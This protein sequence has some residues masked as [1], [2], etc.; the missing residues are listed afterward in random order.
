MRVD[1]GF[2]INHYAGKVI[3]NASG[4]LAKNRDALP[5][6]IILLLRSSENELIRKLVTNPLTK[7]A[8]QPYIVRGLFKVKTFP[9]QSNLAHTKGK[10][11]GS[12]RL[13][14]RQRSP[15]RSVN[16]VKG[17]NGAES[18]HHPRETTNM[19][20][21][22]V[23]SYFR[24]SLMDLLSKMVAGQ[25][26]FIRCIK[27]NNDR[28]A[29]KF[30]REKVLIQLRYTGI[31]ETAKIRRQGY[32]HRILFANFIQRYY[33][34]AF[35]MNEEP[36]VSRETCAAILEKAKLENWA[37]GKTK[38]FLKYYHVEHLNLMVRRTMDRV[39]L[40]QAYVRCWLVVQ[41]YRK[42]LGKRAQSAVVLQSAFR[43][44][45]VRKQMADDKT[46]AEQDT[47]IVELQ[48]VCRGYLARK[49]YKELVDEKNKA[50]TK[51]QAHFRGHKERRSFQRKKE[52][53]QKEN[54][55]NTEED[56]PVEESK[57]SAD[58]AQEDGVK[59]PGNSEGKITPSA[60]E[61]EAASPES[62]EE[63][64]PNEAT[65]EEV[66]T[67]QEAKAATVIQSNFRGY[68]ERKKLQEDGQLPTKGKKDTD[69]QTQENNSE[70]KTMEAGQVTEDGQNPSQGQNNGSENQNESGS[71][72]K[73][74]AESRTAQEEPEKEN[75]PTEPTSEGQNGDESRQMD[76]EQA[77][78]EKSDL[79]SFSKHISSV[80]QD[81]LMLQQ[82]L[83]Q[84][85]MAHQINPTSNGMFTRG[86]VVNGTLGTDQ[87][88]SAGTQQ[89]RTSRRSTKPKTLSTPEDSTYYSL[90]HRS[91]QDDKKRTRK[92]SSK[93]L[94]D[95]DDQYYQSLNSSKS[96]S[97]TSGDTE[98]PESEIPTSD[99]P[100]SPNQNRHSVL[101]MLSMEN[102]D[103]PYDY[104]KLLRK[105]SQRGRLIEQN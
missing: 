55:Q 9:L 59:E 58:S 94:L 1:L 56:V 104:R 86:H 71:E 7:T 70:E 96:T 17:E 38:V 77:Q 53:L 73:I 85:I 84:I 60:D 64:V 76:D 99:T 74:A 102:E 19:R 31:L 43:G 42:I 91:I 83:N 50:A 69:Q 36:A 93:K 67:E 68:K 97:E 30:D 41:S 82:K 25:P 27:P 48:A 46:K 47:V 3:Y 34:L 89:I 66:N 95:T 54:E 8:Y 88:L 103:N 101:R 57:S 52:A 78:K 51:I 35:R 65:M 98:G 49:K 87:Q 92:Q 29:H 63:S 79:E 37:L 33:M 61:P 20:T 90:I 100:K 24:Y 13:G 21:Q 15:Q 32:S 26:H 39:V 16:I 62:G 5:A 11:T 75:E 6:D 18:I 72:E 45:M 105:T 44:H 12:V 40:L 23:A 22:T 80:S 4:F 14:S 81:F 10:G 2:G 28:Q